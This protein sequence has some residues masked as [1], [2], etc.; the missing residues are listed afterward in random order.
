MS[1]TRVVITGMGVKTPAG[2]DLDTF[3]SAPQ[4]SRHSILEVR[5]EKPITF[6]HALIMEWLIEGQHIQQYAIEV[7]R[8]GKWVEVS[9]G[10]AIG[11]KRIDSFEPVTTSRVR[12]NIL[13]SSA[14]AHIREFQL[15]ALSSLHPPAS[16]H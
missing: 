2:N 1:R 11:H 10:R 3:W 9:R 14:E 7:L 16:S 6:D 5:F 4:G 15:F 8:E 13:S 12:L